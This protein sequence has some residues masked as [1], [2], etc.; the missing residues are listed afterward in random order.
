MSPL[1]P[2]VY[3]VQETNHSLVKAQVYGQ[4]RIILPRDRGS[5][6]VG[7]DALKVRQALEDVEPDDW[8]LPTGDPAAIAVAAVEFGRLTG[9]LRILRWDRQAD[10]YVPLEFVL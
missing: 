8:L 9:R 7:S 3:V 5:L 1:T 2:T 6:R 4:T 10:D